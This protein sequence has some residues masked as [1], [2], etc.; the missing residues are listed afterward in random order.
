MISFNNFADLQNY[1]NAKVNQFSKMQNNITLYGL[2]LIM[3][4]S[5]CSPFKRSDA[6]SGATK[7]SKTGGNSLYHQTD[8]VSLEAGELIIAGE[9]KQPGKVDLSKFY[10]RE[11]V[12]KECLFNRANEPEFTGAFRY[13]GYSLFDL[14]NDYILLKKNSEEFRPEIDV[15]IKIE[16]DKGEFVAFSWSEI[17]HTINPH[18]VI[19]ATEAAPIKP[20]R[21]E[22]DYHVSNTWKVIASNDLFSYRNLENPVKIIVGSFDKKKYP[23]NRDLETVYSSSLSV[24]F[25]E[26]DPAYSGKGFTV[27][28]PVDREKLTRYHSTFYGMGMGYHDKPTFDGILLHEVLK[29]S[30]NFFD[31]VLIKNG[32]VCFAA[33]D[34]YRT[35]FSFS[36]LFN[37]TDQVSPLLS[38]TESPNDGGYFRIYMPTDFYADRSVKA[39]K[40]IY[41]FREL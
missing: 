38:I 35:I 13:S 14:L 9:V 36:E 11:V 5:A 6:T 21:K 29:D 3:I 34:G 26:A 8:E 23:I 10:K 15:Y 7:S 31:G 32:L 27:S 39:L 4:M 37:R 30:V 24:V 41:I 1:H 16:N 12:V 2:V 18:Q 28:Q 33:E 25:D 22:V 20:H 40:E 19:I 17:F